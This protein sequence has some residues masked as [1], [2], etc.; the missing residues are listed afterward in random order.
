MSVQPATRD[1]L[2]WP[3][4]DGLTYWRQRALR[5]EAMQ[6]QQSTTQS[7]EPADHIAD[8]SKMVSTALPLTAQMARECVDALDD[9]ARMNVGV[10]AHGA[11]AT[12]N[13]FIDTTTQHQ[14]VA[15]MPEF[16]VVAWSSDDGELLSLKQLDRL[17]NAL[18]RF[19]DVAAWAQQ[20]VSQPAEP[21]QRQMT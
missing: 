21:V 13:A 14:Q 9:F 1:A 15:A 18:V 17:Q 6:S 4:K 20:S 16:E 12:L 19:K 5:A 11:V 10:N 7:A 2:P 3:G 8:A